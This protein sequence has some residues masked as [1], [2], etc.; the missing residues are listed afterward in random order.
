MSLLLVIGLALARPPSQ[1]EMVGRAVDIAPS[2]YQYRADRPAD[3][4]PPESWFALMHFARLPL[5]KPVD[6]SNALVKHS[7]C[8]LLW[9]EIRPV[10]S[11]ELT[12]PS[13]AKR[14]PPPGTITVSALMN[15]GPSS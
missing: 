9:E 15:Q 6:A 7:L 14:I 5:N 4:N 12:W 11:I 3:A 10:Q 13:R 1:A 2:A 8:G